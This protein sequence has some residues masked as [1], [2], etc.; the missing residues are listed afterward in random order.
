[1]KW[2]KRRPMRLFL[3]RNWPQLVLSVVV[4][5]SVVL[6][7]LI[8]AQIINQDKNL[9]RKSANNE[10]S[11]TL[12]ATT[13]LFTLNQLLY[14]DTSGE[15]NYYIESRTRLNTLSEMMKNWQVGRV[16]TKKSSK[17][18]YLTALNRKDSILVG[19]GHTVTQNGI[20]ATIG[21]QYKLPENATIDFIQ[22]SAQGY[23]SEVKM[24]DNRHQTIYIFPVILARTTPN[25]LT[26]EGQRVKTELVWQNQK[27]HMRLL[28][29]IPLKV[30]TYLLGE[31]SPEVFVNALFSGSD[32]P[33]RNFQTGNDVQYSDGENR[34][35]TE[36]VNNG[37]MVFD[38][39]NVHWPLNGLDK[40]ITTATKWA[41]KIHQ[42]ADNLG[43]FE[44]NSNH[45][46]LQ[47]RVFVDGVPVF[48]DQGFGAVQV[49]QLSNRHLRMQFSKY[50]LKVPLPSSKSEVVYLPSVEEQLVAL[51]KAG[52]K[53]NKIENWSIG[54]QWVSSEDNR[55]VT[56][57]PMWF[58][59]LKD[60]SW[61]PIQ[62]DMQVNR[63]L[64]GGD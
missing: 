4:V 55:F 6:S 18:A 28:Q 11:V 31:E 44:S 33:Q 54:Y 57:N 41:N 47:F 52:V 45:R 19:F 53:T 58:V 29:K 8:W 10:A 50:T 49:I 2:D 62:N 34:Q 26:F 46:T 13:N 12:G 59:Q 35:L 51:K 16:I 23:P 3:Q 56:L 37:S 39:Y 63:T 40:H 60:D 36:N 5:L 64:L 42:S 21:R 7:L 9:I 61:H 38:N 14:T 48:S 27:V 20:T 32:I 22:V 15:T 30:H 25:K 17:A 43:Y 24:Y 1:M